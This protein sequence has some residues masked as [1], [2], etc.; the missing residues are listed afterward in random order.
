MKEKEIL[1]LL[2]D[3]L[4]ITQLN[5]MQ[6]KMMEMCVNH[7]NIILLSP[8]GS[9]KT[10]AFILPILK[11]L[12]PSIGQVQA[13]IIAPGREL[14]TQIAS[15]FREVA[16]GFKVTAIYGG[17]K[18]EDEAN[19]LSVTPDIVVA[20]PGRL[21]DHAVRGNIDLTPV[22]ILVLDEFDKSLELGFAG[23]MER[24]VKRLKNVSRIILTSATDI[25]TLPDFLKLADPL[26][27]DFTGKTAPRRRMRIHRVDSDVAD[28]LESLL[29]LL[30]SLANPDGT[31]D[32]T[33]VFVNH[34]ESATRTYRWLRKRGVPVGLY[35]GALDQT[36]R[37]KAVAMFNNGTTPVL[38][39][40]DLA[41]RGLDIAAVSNVIHYHQPLTPDAWT[42]RNG[43]T[44]R[45]D[46]SGDIYVIVGPTEDVA[47]FIDIDDTFHTGGPESAHLHSNVATIYFGAGKKEKISRG[48]ILG[49]LIKVC[50]VEGNEVGKILVAD[51]FALAAVPS[52]DVARILEMARTTKIKG[53]KIKI[54]RATPADPD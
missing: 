24:L 23:E 6:K 12:K 9:G 49:F 36:D 18:V 48:D 20:T 29:R 44:A 5:D 13:V 34:R 3:R 10:L 25:A 39:A 19:S 1:P 28:K 50:G 15:I 51:R 22:R 38:I 17:H 42:H 54:D 32:R 41:A 26:R 21:L 33:I 30:C 31:I 8:T 46:A 2:K 14:V 27:L 7:H 11:L 43:R 16:A 37:E 53:K 47:E 45:V 52:G 4:G 40:T 35:H